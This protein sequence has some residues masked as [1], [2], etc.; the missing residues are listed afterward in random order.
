MSNHKDF[1]PEDIR[2]MVDEIA[3]EAND[4]SSELHSMLEEMRSASIASAKFDVNLADRFLA[5]RQS[6]VDLVAYVKSRK[7]LH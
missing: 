1:T 4:P 2:N 6:F 7:E 3:A 5:I